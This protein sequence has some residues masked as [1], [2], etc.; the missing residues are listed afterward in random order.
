MPWVL[1]CGYSE[2]HTHEGSCYKIGSKGRVI[3][4]CPKRQHT[5]SAEGGSCYMWKKG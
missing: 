2:E 5:H 4:S 1:K 3:V